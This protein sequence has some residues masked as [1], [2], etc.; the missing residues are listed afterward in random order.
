M[1]IMIF[2]KIVAKSGVG[3]HIRMLSAELVKQGHK[4]VVVSTTNN[5]GIGNDGGG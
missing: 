4:V 5:L 3:N 2:S 1:N